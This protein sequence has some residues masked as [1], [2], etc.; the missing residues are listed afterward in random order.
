MYLKKFYLIAMKLKYNFIYYYLNFYSDHN[1]D[2][3]QN[4]WLTHKSETLN[5]ILNLFFKNTTNLTDYCTVQSTVNSKLLGL[6]G[7]SPGAMSQSPLD[8]KMYRCKYTCIFK[9][10]RQLAC[11]TDIPEDHLTW[12]NI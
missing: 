7:K 4:S 11:N 6:P 3:C 1:L 12:I 9:R 2:H 5:I 10:V 8:K